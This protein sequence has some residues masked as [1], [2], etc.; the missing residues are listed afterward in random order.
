VVI[1]DLA[2]PDWHVAGFP[3]SDAFHQ[4][5]IA[6]LRRIFGNDRFGYVSMRDL[7][8]ADNFIDSGHPKPRLWPV[9]SS[10]L[11]D[12]LRSSRL[13]EERPAPAR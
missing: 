6:R 8:A 2:L 13:L 10:R 3:R 5:M 12:W 4:A 7:G 11:A 1:C 9:I